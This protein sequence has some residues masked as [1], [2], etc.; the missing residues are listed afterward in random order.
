MEWPPPS[1]NLNPIDLN[2]WSIV[3]IELYKSGKKYNSKTDL[4]EAIKI[5]LSETKPA[6]VKIKE[7]KLVV[8]KKIVTILKRKGF[9][10]LI[11]VFV[12]FSTIC[13]H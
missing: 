11:Y 5:I 1:P 10:D 8:T 2:Q 13:F 7:S 6:E 3:K 12:I 4:W 9:K